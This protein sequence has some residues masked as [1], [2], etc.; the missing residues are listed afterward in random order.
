MSEELEHLLRLAKRGQGDGASGGEKRI[1]AIV[2]T[3]LDHG[4]G[5]DDR[6][7]AGVIQ[8]TQAIHDKDF[9][10]INQFW[11]AVA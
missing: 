11:D 5:N 4:F 1:N 6:A 8:L 9:E 7:I 2:E 3:L 10:V